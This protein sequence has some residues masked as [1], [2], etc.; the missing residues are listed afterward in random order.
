[1]ASIE[2]TTLCTANRGWIFDDNWLYGDLSEKLWLV[3]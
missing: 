2:K 1:M 3:V